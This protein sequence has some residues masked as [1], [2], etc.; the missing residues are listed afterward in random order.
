MSFSF[1][2]LFGIVALIAVGVTT[3]MLTF[4][5]FAIMKMNRSN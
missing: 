4:A 2:A 5:A 1:T 3:A